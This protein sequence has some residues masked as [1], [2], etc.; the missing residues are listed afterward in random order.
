L[1]GYR[2]GSMDVFNPVLSQSEG[3]ERE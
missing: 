1:E 2:T 3:K